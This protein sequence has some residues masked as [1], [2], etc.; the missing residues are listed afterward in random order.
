LGHYKM[1]AYLQVLSQEDFDKWLKQRT[2]AQ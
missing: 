1:R 2:A